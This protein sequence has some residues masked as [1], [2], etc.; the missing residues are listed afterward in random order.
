MDKKS[1][2]MI[3]N[4]STRSLIKA[5][6]F[7]TTAHF[8]NDFFLSF[9]APTLPVL[10]T[11]MGLLKVQAGVLNL[12]LELMALSMP[13]IGKIADKK[14]LRKFIFFTPT[15]TA[16]CMSSLGVISNFYLLLLVLLTGGF[17]IYFYHAIGPADVANVGE[18]TLGRLMA[19]WNIAGQVAFMIGPLVVTWV[20]TYSSVR[21]LPWLSAIGLLI[22]GALFFMRRNTPIKPFEKHEAQ[23]DKQAP[24]SGKSNRHILRQFLPITAIILLISLSRSC[25]YAY[26]PVYIVE[27]GG[28]LWMSG[29][30]I[31]LYFG[32]GII[33]NFLGGALHDHIGSK[34]VSAIALAG[35]AVFF[36][37]TIFS[38][39]ALQLALI[40]LMG[41]F[42]FML[43]PTIMAMLA[44]NNPN[45][46]SLTNGLFLGFSYGIIAMAGVLAGYL[47][48]HF[49][50][51]PV[52]L[53][54]AA[55]ALLSVACV[56]FLEDRPSA[57]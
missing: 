18:Q 43:M 15:V 50:T 25:A 56:P 35:F 55:L 42:S 57:V 7:H 17:S 44:K 51:I 12:G 21:Q 52:F 11:Q 39:G 14:D 3:R 2:K 38:A 4:N 47:L 33:G 54:S 9:F 24:E 30:A 6:L 36:A 45:D 40:F 20:I 31:S 27:Q 19:I 22:S 28:S 53:L 41:I 46:R 29:L 49:S 16:I 32:A 8:A 5:T 1:Q 34:K 48:D 23:L 10:I 37:A 26:L 13:L